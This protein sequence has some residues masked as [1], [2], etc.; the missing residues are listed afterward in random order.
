[1][2]T[3]TSADGWQYASVFK[4]EAH[5]E[6]LGILVSMLCFCM[7]SSTYSQQFYMCPSG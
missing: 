1:M 2:S 4:C 6:A 7:L 3:A 5:C